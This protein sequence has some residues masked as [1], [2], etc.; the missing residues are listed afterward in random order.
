MMHRGCK[1]TMSVLVCPDCNGKFPIWRR[2]SSTREKGHLKFIW[3]PFCKEVK[4]CTE[5]R[6][7]DEFDEYKSRFEITLEKA[8]VV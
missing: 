6:S 1:T 7:Q 4:N 8:G 3:C 5:I 2:K